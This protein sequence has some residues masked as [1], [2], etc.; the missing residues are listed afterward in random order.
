MGV[1]VNRE[2]ERTLL[3]EKYRHLWHGVTR[4][5]GFQATKITLTSKVDGCQP[6]KEEVSEILEISNTGSWL[7]RINTERMFYAGFQ[8]ES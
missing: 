8:L 3:S 4:E 5:S 2:K 7:G 1:G 6:N